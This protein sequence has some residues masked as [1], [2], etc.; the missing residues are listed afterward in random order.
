MAFQVVEYKDVTQPS[1]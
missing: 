1:D